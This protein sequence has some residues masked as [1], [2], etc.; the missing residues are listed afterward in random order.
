M[1]QVRNYIDGAFVD[2]HS[3]DRIDDICPADGSLLASIPRSGTQDVDRA[4]AAAGE[5]HGDAGNGT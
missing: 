5:S 3:A 1:I 4:A 2:A